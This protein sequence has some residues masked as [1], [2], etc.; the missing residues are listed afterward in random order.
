MAGLDR[1]FTFG[2]REEWVDIYCKYDGSSSFWESD[3]DGYVA[4][5]KKDAF[6]NFALDAGLCSFDKSVSGGD[7]Y[8]KCVASDFLPVVKK[9]GAKSETS[10]ALI[11]CNLCYTPTFNWFV[12]S[13]LPG[14]VYTPE[15]VKMMLS[16]YMP[17]D[18]K[19]LGKRNIIDSFKIFMA[20]TPLGTQCIFANCDILRIRKGNDEQYSMRSFSR[21]SW[22]EPTTEVILYSL[23]KFAEACSSKG[24]DG[25]PKKKKK[26]KVA[27][28]K[29]EL[30]FNQFTLSYLLDDTIERDGVSPTRI[31]GLDKETMIRI[32][33]GLSINYPEFI[34]VSFTLDMDNITLRPD[35]SS[36][37]VLRLF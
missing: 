26:E 22:K 1:Y 34:S 3:G 12:K 16:D 37:D 13:L 15:I 32:L 19:D 33:N 20:K 29:K 4:S 27:D 9:L 7:K 36:Q 21:C 2:I 17:D 11:L 23:Y 5:K 28:E 18:K 6:M 31:F 8:T 25:I 10:W 14:V 30:S 35:K 24:E